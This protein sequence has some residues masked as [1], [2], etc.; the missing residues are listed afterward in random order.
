[1]IEMANCFFCKSS[2]VVSQNGEFVHC[3]NIGCKV[4]H[5]FIPIELWRG[6]DL[7][8]L[9]KA[10]DRKY[11]PSRI[12]YDVVRDICADIRNWKG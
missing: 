5:H 10:I 11:K 9:A 2:P 4:S 12:E 1:M 7:D 3:S 6:M 8:G